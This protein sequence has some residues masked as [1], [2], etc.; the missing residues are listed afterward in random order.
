MY[1]CICTPIYIYIYMQVHMH[2]CVLRLDSASLHNS[3]QVKASGHQ[4]QA[5]VPGLS[6]RLQSGRVVI[7]V[8]FV[9]SAIKSRCWH[10]MW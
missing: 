5:T 2:E 3:I 9:S 8:V 4:H 6:V 10:H 7:C 1:I